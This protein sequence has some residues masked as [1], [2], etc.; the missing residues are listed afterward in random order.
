M[1]KLFTVENLL[2]L[3]REVLWLAIT[4]II[5]VAILYPITSKI[6]YIYLKP[7]FAFIMIT[8]TYFRWAML[9]RSLPFLRPALIRFLLFTVNLSLTI[10]IVQI[11]QKVMGLM[12]NMYTEDIGFPKVI[13][14]EADRAALFTYVYN[15]VVLFGTGAVLMIVAFNLRLIIS[16]WQFYKYKANTLMED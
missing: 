1:G 14:F 4:V 13:L 6:D 2:H 9:I 10:Y 11:M 16:W 12:E 7:T 3:L 5:A 15:V 8:L